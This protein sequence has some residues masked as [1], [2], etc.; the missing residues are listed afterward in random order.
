MHTRSLGRRS[1]TQTSGYIVATTPSRF[2]IS[3]PRPR[4]PG[5]EEH[6]ALEHRVRDEQ[7]ALS[8][9][10]L[11]ARVLHPHGDHG[12]HLRPDS[13]SSQEPETGVRDPDRGQTPDNQEQSSLSRYGVTVI[14]W[15]LT[16][17]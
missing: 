15:A 6:H 17:P 10:R 9:F 2:I 14:Q 16:R 12:G 7:P 4:P 3:H 13:P 8:H 1:P 11:P 5:H